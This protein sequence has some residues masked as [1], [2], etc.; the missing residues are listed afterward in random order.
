MKYKRLYCSSQMLRDGRIYV[1]GGEFGTGDT[2]GEVFDPLAQQWTTAGPLPAG[3]HINDGNSA[4]LPDG[5]VLQ[6][7]VNPARNT[8]IYNPSTNKYTV[9]PATLGSHDEAAWLKLPDNSLLFVDIDSRR[10]ERF[11]PS[12]NT[13]LRDADVPVSLYD[14]FGKETG[15]AFLLPD[16]RAFFIGGRGYTAYYSPSGTDSP[17][18]WTAGPIIPDSLSAPDAAAAMMTN[19]KILCAFSPLPKFADVFRSPMWFY[20]F[21]YRNNSFARINAPN[22]LD[23]LNN[24]CYTTM[25]LALPDGNIL[26]TILASKEYY[27]YQPSGSQVESGIPNL[28]TFIKIDCNHYMATGY[29]FNGISEGAAYGD[30]WQMST[31]YP[32]IRL[33]QHDNI[34]GDLVHYTR[35]YNWN[36]TGVMRG[37]QKDTVYFSLPVGLADGNYKLE[38]VTNGIPST[39]YNFTTCNTVGLSKAHSLSETDFTVSPNPAT[40]NALIQYTSTDK[41]LSVLLT[42]PLGRIILRKNIQY[43]TGNDFQIDLTGLPSG[44]YT[45]TGIS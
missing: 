35:T 39:E 42:D 13:W 40:N 6:G 5:R 29:G 41:L 24:P 38:L 28:D 21:D 34:Y 11:I 14:T 8:V 30:D 12:K 7:I 4:L 37:S 15:A 23:T 10:S 25:M 19:G 2:N 27:V 16:G 32:L 17:G 9:G 33:I 26:F 3:F 36:S 1:A 45:I 20:E 31:N 44:V 18:V 43:T 22:G